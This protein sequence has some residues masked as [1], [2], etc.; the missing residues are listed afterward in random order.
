[1]GE[2]KAG[3]EK[4]LGQIPQAQLVPQPP[5]RDEQHDID[6]IFQVV[7]R[8][9]DALVEGSLAWLSQQNVR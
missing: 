9:D 4:H 2:Y 5:H 8:G 6:G 7:E 1:M 3:L